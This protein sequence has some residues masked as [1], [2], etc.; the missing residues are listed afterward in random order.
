M[1]S[2]SNDIFSPCKNKV[3]VELWVQDPLGACVITNKEK[4]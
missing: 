3:K 4:V 1:S 2:R